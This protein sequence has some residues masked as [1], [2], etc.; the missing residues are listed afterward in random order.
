MGHRTRSSLII[1]HLRSRG[2]HVDIIT[3]GPQK[4]ED[5]Q[6]VIY[7][8]DGLDFKY[9]KNGQINLPKT[10][11]GQK[12]SKFIGD[13]KFLTKIIPGYDF[14]ISDFEPLSSWSC[15]F[16]RK[17]CYLISNQSYFLSKNM[18]RSGILE[19]LLYIITKIIT[20]WGKIIPLHFMPRVGDYYPPLKKKIYLSRGSKNEENFYL[21]YLKGF[22]FLE[23]FKHLYEN[24]DE[25]F[26]FYTDSTP[27]GKYTN[28]EI[29]KPDTEEFAKDLVRCK[30]VITGGGFSTISECLF[31]NK[32]LGVIPIKNQ[33]EQIFNAKVLSGLGFWVASH[34]RELVN[35]IQSKKITLDVV[36]TPVEKIVN[37]I[38]DDYNKK[39]NI[40]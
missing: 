20:P 27:S 34:P 39:N 28:I 30:G 38:I 25:N 19:N 11:T 26:I 10:I 1:D 9:K 14:V 18:T 37:V 7:S 24:K 12:I 3:S 31:L 32:K 23:I 15:L 22:T 2:H 21:V 8:F 36:P 17:K 29:K 40:K 16:S 5:I 33:P 6:G 13:V 35:F 4:I